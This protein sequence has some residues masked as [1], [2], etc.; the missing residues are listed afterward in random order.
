V[1]FAVME[2]SQCEADSAEEAK[3]MVDQA[4]SIYE[5]P[6]VAVVANSVAELP[7]PLQEPTVTA[8]FSGL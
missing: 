3:A 8:V 7:H 2:I 1:L 5:H 4:N 6:R